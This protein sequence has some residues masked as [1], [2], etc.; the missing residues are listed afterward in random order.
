M[1]PFVRARAW[2]RS[3]AA[4]C[5]LLASFDVLA[6]PPESA[7][8]SEAAE[9]VPPKL[10]AP[11][12]FD[13]PPALLERDEPPGGTITMQYVV[14]TDGVP[15]EIEVLASPDPELDAL[16]VAVIER[17]RYEP[18]TFEGEPVE[19][20]LSLS[21]EVMPPTPSEPEPE[22][23]E[24]PEPSDASEPG[25]ASQPSDEPEP[26]GPVRIGGRVREA[27]PRTPI[28]GATILAIPAGDLPLGP[29]EKTLYEPERE[30]EWQFDARSDAEG[31]F[32]LRGVPEGKVRVILIAPGFE[33][34]E[35]VVMLAPGKALDVD[36][37][38][39]RLPTNP[40]TTIVTSERESMPEVVERTLSVEEIKSVPGSQGDALK[41]VLNFPGVARAPFGSGQLAIRGSAPEDSAIYFG[42]HEIPIL[43][44]FGG[45]RSVVASEVLAEIDFIPGNFDSRYGDAIGGVVNVQPRKGRRDGFHGHIDTNLFDTGARVEGPVGK[46][47]FL[48]AA[49][50]SYIDFLLPRVIPADAGLN[51]AVAP[52]YWDYQAFFDYPVSDGELS[53][54][55]F[56]SDDRTKLVFADPNDETA[57]AA[58]NGVETKQ[59]FHRA[60]IVYRKQLGPWEL[61]VTPAYRRSRTALSIFD[62]LDLD[63]A[64]LDLTG[65]AELSQQVTKS[66]RWR[67]GTEITATSF[68]IDVTAPQ[69]TVGGS[70]A[71]ASSA[72]TREVAATLFRGA[73]YSTVTLALGERVTLFPGVRF[74]WYA[75]PLDR[76]AV[77]PRL[78]AA[79]ELG[80]TTTLKAATGLYTQGIQQPV[81]LDSSFG[82]PRLGLQRSFHNSLGIAQ[83]L[84]WEVSLEV[85]GFYKQLW[86]LVV[87]SS[88]LVER[89]DG[90]IGPETFSNLGLGRIY[91]LELLLRKQLSQNFYGWISYTL[92]RSQRRLA[93]GEP[94]T[95]FD[96][97]QTHILT[98]IASYEM[99]RGWRLGARFRL[100]SGN[101][102]TPT[103]DGVFDAATGAFTAIQGPLNG[104]RLPA[105]HQLDLRL[106]KTWTWPVL[107]FSIYAD[108]QNVYNRQNVE[109]LNFGYD[110]RTTLPVNSLP[111][112]PA[113]GFRIEF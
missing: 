81:Q 53:V 97:D 51:F 13:Y 100:V 36:F 91:G 40:Y 64:T 113:L 32:A 28:E 12:T 14:G 107:Q 99:P 108:V 38:P 29:I 67:V 101:P 96:F 84:P 26:S 89:P 23:S 2:A 62:V 54:R 94:F 110:F 73:L 104:D 65:R 95:L 8:E 98:I 43:F 56:G 5:S 18:A 7:P 103:T 79:F 17:L 44:H 102:F 61:L 10:I 35:Q 105:F 87:P 19:V 49:R 22:P 59:W 109:F 33:R 27:G 45:V 106:D 50:R 41:A 76:A 34:N 3:V 6:G 9:L 47:S 75:A 93:P 68:D 30:L 21:F 72:L 16:G 11:V 37:W 24:G 31:R 48:V 66:L 88:L 69:F 112:L 92:S 70:G 57:D 15:F 52:R 4:A 58:R 85:T 20:V 1:P 60:D 90:E 82:N 77:D 71:A 42:Y 111:I 83:K 55:M 25:D 46:G 39:R 74:E 78:R 63:V 86:D 80:P